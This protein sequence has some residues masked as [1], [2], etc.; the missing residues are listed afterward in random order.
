MFLSRRVLAVFINLKS[1]GEA[2][3]LHFKANIS[4]RRQILYLFPG[5]LTSLF[6]GE[7]V[8]VFFL[9]NALCIEGE[10]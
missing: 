5:L 2:L 3:R 4:Q 9:K 10:H 1:D 7:L 8:V 6:E